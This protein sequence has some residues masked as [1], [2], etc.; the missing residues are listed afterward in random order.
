MSF[1]QKLIN[2]VITAGPKTADYN[3]PTFGPNQSNTLT[4]T[5]HRVRCDITLAGMLSMSPSNIEI[6]GMNESDMNAIS[7]LGQP[8]YGGNHNLVTVL[9]GDA[10]NGMAIAFEGVMTSALIDFSA[11]P[12]ASF[13]IQA[14]LGQDWAMYSAPAQNYPGAVSIGTICQQIA[15]QMGL[16]LENNGCTQVLR[17]QYLPGTLLD[18]LQ[19]ATQAAGVLYFIERGVL[20]IW[21]KAGYRTLQT[22]KQIISP[23]SGLVGYPSYTNFG[24]NFRCLYNPNLRYGTLVEIQSSQ[25]PACGDWKIVSMSHTLNSLDPDAAWFTDIQTCKPDMLVMFSGW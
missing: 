2:V 8:Y 9:A 20:A 15:A 16:V 13:N 1:T 5:G 3:P 14:T 25:K 24:V 19:A 23:D 22:D 11:P 21:P 6:F 17:D 10:E 4:L 7:S 12:G 18:Q